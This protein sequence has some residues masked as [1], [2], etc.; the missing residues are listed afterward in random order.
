MNINGKVHHIG[1]THPGRVRELNEDALD[2]DLEYG[3]SVLADGMG[4]YNA[5]EIAS[6]ITV[7][8]VVE[9][10]KA[11]L[12]KLEKTAQIDSETGFTWESI[13]LR[14]SVKRANKIVYQT[15]NSKDEY[16]GMGTTVVACLLFDI[17]ISIAH[18]GDSRCYRLR[19]GNFEQLTTDHSLLQ[20]LVSRGFYSK[21]E[22]ARSL[23]KNYVTRAV[24]VDNSVE[25]DIMED[26]VRVGDIYLLCSDGLSDMLEDE[27]IHL[28]IRTFSD[29]LDIAAKQLIELSNEHGGRDNITVSLIQVVKS[30]E[31]SRGFFKKLVSWF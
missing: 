25:V 3:V 28:T 19:A 21:E 17:R 4:G 16:H 20:E 2:H 8:T 14:D 27:D 22:A 23:N 30:F 1:L 18:V 24:G 29:N 10:V 26:I 31:A 5:G 13:V 9:M 11:G 15:A 12:G 6:E 7:R